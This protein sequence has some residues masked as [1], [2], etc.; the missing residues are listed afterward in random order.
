MNFERLATDFAGIKLKTP[1]MGASG[2]FGFGIEYK[3]FLNLG[4]VGAIISKG[5]TPLPR[6]G[7]NGVRVAETPGGMLNCIG[8]ENPGIEGFLRDIL[9]KVRQEA[10]DTA[11]IANFSAGTVEDYG[12]MAARLDV[13]GVDGV[14]VNISCPN[15]KEGG[16]VFGTDPRAAAAVTEAVKKN[17]KKPVIVKLSPN[18]TDIALMARAV[19]EAGADAIALINTLTGMVIDTRTWQPLLGNITGGLSGPAVKPIAVRMVWQAAQAVKIPILGLGGITCG[20]DAVEFLLAGASAVAVGAENFVH[21]DA[22]VR[23]AEDI[24]AYLAARGLEHVSQL[25]GQVKL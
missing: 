21:P 10:A 11:F 22:V 16:I 5:L 24:D 14:E 9:P 13:D 7:N 6:P 15:V 17:T 8:L 18:V 19:E 4:D 25:V 12:M 1:V 23:V 20:E 2:T 3:D